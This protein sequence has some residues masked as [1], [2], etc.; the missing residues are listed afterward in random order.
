MNDTIRDNLYVVDTSSFVELNDKYP[1]YISH[2]KS[3]WMLLEYL[4]KENF[5]I[6]HEYVIKELQEKDDDI[7]NWA[8]KW[9]KKKG[10]F[11]KKVDKYCFLNYIILYMI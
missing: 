7:Y 11:V 1:D 4:I 6:T 10:H 5:L 8:K 3:I 9:K 2:F